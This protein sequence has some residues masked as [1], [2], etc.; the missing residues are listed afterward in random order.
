[1]RFDLNETGLRRVFREWQVSVLEYL[2]KIDYS[3][4]SVDVWNDLDRNE[5]TADPNSMRSVSRASVIN[6]LNQLVD[7][8]L[9]TFELESG[10]GGY[11]RIYSFKPGLMNREDFKKFMH[12][13]FSVALLD[14]LENE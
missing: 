10:K 8:N 11:H 6:F 5:V 4:K 13:L 7:E 3:V 9:M 14:F 2:W 12:T 1:M